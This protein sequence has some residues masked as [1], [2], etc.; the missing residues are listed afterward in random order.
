[1]QSSVERPCPGERVTFTCTVPSLAHQWRISSFGITRSL[2]PASGQ[3][4][5]FSDPPFQFAV[6]EVRTGTSI[7]ST[8]TLNVTEDLNSTLIVC[9]DGNLVF[10]DQNSTI[11]LRGELGMTC[12]SNVHGWNKI[13]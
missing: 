10:P 11:N 9:Q 7:T 6:T 1:M 5:V 12:D 4:Q 2:T 8:A 13:V 3:G